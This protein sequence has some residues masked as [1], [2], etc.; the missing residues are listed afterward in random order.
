MDIT[1]LKVDNVFEKP[2][3]EAL[4][5]KKNSSGNSMGKNVCSQVS[6]THTHICIYVYTCA[7]RRSLRRL[8]QFPFSTILAQVE[9]CTADQNCKI[10]S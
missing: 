4:K 10:C 7:Y 9:K 1:Q 8:A 6:Y 5:E 3:K 2:K